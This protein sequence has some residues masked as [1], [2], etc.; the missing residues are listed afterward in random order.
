[1][2]EEQKHHL[3]LPADIMWNKVCAPF[4]SGEYCNVKTESIITT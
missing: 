3:V 4:H 1:M 2:G